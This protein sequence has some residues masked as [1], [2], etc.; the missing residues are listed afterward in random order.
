MNAEFR[1]VATC[2]ALISGLPV[3]CTAH[4]QDTI[5]L[6]VRV[7][8]RTRATPTNRVVA[9]ELSTGVDREIYRS[10]GDILDHV[11]L[12]PGGRYVAFVEV[13]GPGGARK[14]RLVVVELSN[15]AIRRYGES[16]IYAAR[17]IR[18]YVWCCGPDLVA[19][20]TG[21]LAQGDPPAGESTTLPHGLSLMDVRTG[22]ATPIEGLRFPL[23]IHW[24]GFD[25]SLYIKDSPDAAPGARGPTVYPIYR[26]HVPTRALSRTMRRGIF[27]SPDGKYYFDTG[28]AEGW[29]RFQ[30]YRTAGDQ[31]VTARL[32]VARHH[33]GPEGGWM[34][35]ADHALL[36]IEKPAP[37]PPKPP[38]P[39]DSTVRLSGPPRPRVFPDRWNLAVDAETGRVIDRFQGDAGAGWKTNAAALPVERR[40]GIN[41]FTVRRP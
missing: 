22:V 39:G 21:G 28:V 24:A 6:L 18:M 35:G 33:L 1:R 2:L 38:Q 12:S 4:A 7:E 14:Q 41:L 19:V 25:S 13:V 31:D 23:Q 15:R 16:S 20:I 8:D 32:A 26:Y 9:R 27:F 30:L 37:Q 17:G 29:G 10:E 34:P 11:A 40:T 3:I 36:F 5:P